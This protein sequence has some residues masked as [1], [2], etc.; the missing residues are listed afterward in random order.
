MQVIGC[1]LLPG[2]E[3]FKVGEDFLRASVA[4]LSQSLRQVIDALL[5]A[6]LV[7]E[8]QGKDALVDPAY[9]SL[10]LEKM[11]EY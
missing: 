7:E 4:F 5:T 1:L 9:D 11:L 10:D 3:L 2:K 8:R 6:S